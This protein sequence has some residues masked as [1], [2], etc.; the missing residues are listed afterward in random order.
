[1][2]RRSLIWISALCLG[3]AVPALPTAAQPVISPTETVD[4]D[5]PE[6]WAMKYFASVTLLT[7]FGPPRDREPGSVEIALE[8]G[9]I[10]HLSEPERTVGFNGIKT[11]D[12]NRSPA[13]VRPR[14]IVGLPG[15]VSLIA[16]WV[17]PVE[18]DGLEANLFALGFERPLVERDAWGLGARLYGQVGS[19]EGDLTCSEPEIRF[20]PGSERNPFGCQ[21]PSDDEA[22]LAYA[23][24]ELVGSRELAGDRA[25]RLHLGLAANWHDHEFQVDALTFGF[26][27]RTLLL[28]DG[29]TWSVNAGATWPLTASTRLGVQAFY[30]P[31]SVDRPVDGNPQVTTDE[32]DNLLN[33]RVLFGWSIR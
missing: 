33:A 21:A 20:E 2:M 26:R 22:D 8:S 18:V 1:M 10:P 7:G 13:F 11:E 16:G 32:E 30:S 12:L 27:D 9:W 5:R 17:P 14:V 3:L 28:A 23:G 15:K 6:A 24:F 19:I 29:W 4:F 31:L 25:P